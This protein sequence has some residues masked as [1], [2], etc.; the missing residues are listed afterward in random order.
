MKNE[1]QQHCD[2]RAAPLFGALDAHA[3][4]RYLGMKDGRYMDE[5]P[6]PRVDLA[7]PGAVRPRWVWRLADLDAHLASRI[8]QPGYPSPW[9]GR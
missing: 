6:I 2:R 4:A 9:S 8:V 3:A 1:A 7:K 5:L